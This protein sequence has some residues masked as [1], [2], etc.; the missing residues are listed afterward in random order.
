MATAPQIPNVESRG[1]NCHSGR[2]QRS[3]FRAVRAQR[4]VET[5]RQVDAFVA[6]LPE[7]T[8]SA[9][10][11]NRMHHTPKMDDGDGG[12]G[13]YA[14]KALSADVAR[15]GGAKHGVVLLIFGEVITHI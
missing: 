6:M 12:V 15:L 10:D 13:R 4:A 8:A 14:S 9:R 2:F 11:I 3:D 7:P 1:R 5:D